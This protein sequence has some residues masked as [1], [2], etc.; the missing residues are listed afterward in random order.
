MV[1]QAVPAVLLCDYPTFADVGMELWE[2]PTIVSHTQRRLWIW[3]CGEWD[4]L[5]WR[6][7]SNHAA[8]FRA[9]SV[10]MVVG[11]G[12]IE[13][14]RVSVADTQGNTTDHNIIRQSFSELQKTIIGIQHLWWHYFLI[15]EDSMTV[16]IGCSFL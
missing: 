12:R 5:L 13:E 4:N 10:E 6:I 11:K 2:V 16:D 3:E 8:C 9:Q 1:K 14:C 15:N 7:W